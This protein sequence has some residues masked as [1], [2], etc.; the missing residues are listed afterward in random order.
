VDDDEMVTACE[1][2]V[3]HIRE[4]RALTVTA[5]YAV[6]VALRRRGYAF[7]EIAEATGYCRERVRMIVKAT[8]AAGE[9]AQIVTGGGAS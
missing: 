6:L 5:R 8:D 9:G 3:R 4:F 1:R 2:V 7:H